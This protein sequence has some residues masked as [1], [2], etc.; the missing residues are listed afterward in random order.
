[1]EVEFIGRLRA[2]AQRQCYISSTIRQKGNDDE[3]TRVQW[4]QRDLSFTRSLLGYFSNVD[5]PAGSEMR[6][7]EPVKPQTPH[8]RFHRR[9]K[10]IPTPKHRPKIHNSHDRHPIRRWKAAEAVVNVAPWVRAERLGH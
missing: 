1:M 5:T 4:R 6:E 2:R 3:T 8:R 10:H 9:H 7:E